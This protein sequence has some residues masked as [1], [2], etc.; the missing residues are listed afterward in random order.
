MKII[1]PELG[2]IYNM[3]L[4][5][6][7]THTTFC[8]GKAEPEEYVHKA[9]KLGFHTLGFSSHAPVPFENSFSLKEERFDEYTETIRGLKESFKDRINIFLSL[10]IDFIPGITKDF[11][12]FVRI[13]NLDYIIGGVHL[14]RNLGKQDLWFIDGSKQ[15]TYDDGLIKL[16]NGNI[17]EGV[18]TYYHQ[19][20]EM[21]V[22]QKPD[23]IAHLDKIKM[24]N[25][26]RYFNEEEKWYKNI[27]WKTL[28]IIA[29]NNSI[30]E[31]NTRGLYKNRSNTTFPGPDILEQVHHLNIPITLS[32]DAHKPEELDGYYKETLPLLRN[33]GFK[34][35]QYFSK[36]GWKN[37][38][39]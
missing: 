12:E 10:E 3:Q 20:Q 25:N 32:S 26:D 16:F 7:H 30:V 2:L 15:Q 22:T 29:E 9:I 4:F 24:H 17:R 27:V 18:E 5:N 28:K 39:I 31:V 11:E 14:V 36:E 13:G 1:F 37:Q 23:I 8:D 19:I 34:Q 38:R 35:L 21:V 6:L 33:I